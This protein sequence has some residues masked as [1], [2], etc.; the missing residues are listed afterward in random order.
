MNFVSI[1]LA[2]LVLAPNDGAVVPT[3]TARQKAY[4]ALP[5]EE[6]IAKF[7]DRDFRRTL[8][9]SEIPGRRGW[10]PQPLA[11]SW[12]GA[13]PGEVRVEVRRATDGAP[14]FSVSTTNRSVEVDNLEIA[15]EY[16][17]TVTDAAGERA[18]ARFTTEDEAPRL[19]RDPGATVPNV[20][21]LGGRV[22][23]GGRR[24][25][26]GLVIRSAGLNEN[27]DWE[28]ASDETIARYDPKGVIP[29]TAEELRTRAGAVAALK[30]ETV[31]LVEV[32]PPEEWQVTR[33]RAEDEPIVRGV[34]LC[35]GAGAEG[36]AETMKVNERGTLLL[37]RHA[38]RQWAHARATLAASAD[39]WAILRC[40]PD[41]YWSFSINGSVV[42]DALA[43]PAGIDRVMLVPVRRGVNELM[44]I[45]GGAECGFRFK[46][47]ALSLEAAGGDLARRI[48]REAKSLNEAADNVTRHH[49]LWARGR[50]RINAANLSFWRDTLGI[51]SDIDLRSDWECSGMTASPLVSAKWFH[52]SSAAYRGIDSSYGRKAFAEVFKVFL[53]ERNYPIDFHCIA[54]QDRTGAVAF[55]VNALLGVEEEEL[56]KD[57]EAT[58]FWNR[59][60]AFNHADYFSKL[61]KVFEQYPGATIN[62]RVEGYVKSLGFTDGDLET[63]RGILLERAL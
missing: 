23:R 40:D 58:G 10:W 28:K 18:T 52:I 49:S 27:A 25:R 37:G 6:R 55:I 33:L 31:A 1:V 13:A 12:T 59:D 51:R 17:W 43:D 47:R 7:A 45:I 8:G 14:V 38:G 57:W 46:L 4:L 5:R 24:V 50:D 36:T 3:H 20:R 35:T 9:E 32:K 29:A 22:G 19:L 48:A 15:R 39:G 41:Y 63:L 62:E 2:A 16:R 60:T 56:Y 11:L 44:V 54:G 53:D 21:D 61:V 30:A 42:R 34:M 26:Q